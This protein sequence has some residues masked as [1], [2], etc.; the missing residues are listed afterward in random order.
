MKIMLIEDNESLATLIIMMLEEKGY[1]V[2]FC[3]RG[4][5]A[6]E[7]FKPGKFDVIISDLKLPGVSGHEILQ[8]VL[9]NDPKAVFIVITAYGNISDAVKSI[10]SGAYDYIAKPFENEDLLNI[11]KK[12][13]EFKKLK[14]ENSNLK[15]YVRDT[16]KPDIVGNSANMKKV[17]G[18][19]D[20]VAATEAPVLLLGESGTGKE[21]VAREIHYRSNRSNQPFVSIN[22]AAIPENLFESEL[23]GHKKGAFTGADKD[24]K[25][26]IQQANGGT[27]FL[28]EIGELPFDSLQAKLLRFLQEKEVEP[29][30]ASGTEK[31][32]VRVIAAT[33]RNLYKMVEENTFREDLYYRLNVF[34]I[35][36][37]PL[38]ER[39]EDL[40]NLVEF[41]LK[42]YGK[43]GMEI[44]SEILEK[45]R[46]YH[47]PGNVREL[48]NTI[49]RMIILSKEG[50]LDASSI[51]GGDYSDI[52]SCLEMDLPED[53]F[54]LAAFEKK[55][56]LRT[57]DKFN[58]NKSRAA[59]YL[60]MPRHVLLYR[61]E[62][63]DNE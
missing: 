15:S 5:T 27:V 23:F 54:D 40:K 33:N 63:F 24:K 16:L 55:I 1:E 18:M 19:V 44:S 37:P 58:G 10:K 34:P 46:G 38:R 4:D 2:T 21:L 28:D 12:A 41:F 50:E 26:K 9:K 22:C 8:Y 14:E 30:G 45:M 39:S 60:N 51:P 25:G 59:K 32:D 7:K 35:K 29:L 48:E 47:W 11:V 20:K 49:Y 43:K 61:L 3:S 42:K 31:V 13:C 52:K 57:L 56:I 36:I 53:S 17:L 62:K 6:L